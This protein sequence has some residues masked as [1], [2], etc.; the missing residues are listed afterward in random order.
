MEEVEPAGLIEREQFHLD[1][2]E[3]SKLFNLVLVA[4][5][6][7]L[8][9]ESRARGTAKL[10]ARRHI[11]SAWMKGRYAGEKNPFFGVRRCGEANPNYQNKSAK[12]PSCALGVPKSP[13]HRAK[14]SATRLER[15]C[16]KGSNHPRYK[17][18]VHRFVHVSGEVFTGSQ[19]EFTQKTCID[20]SSASAVIRGKNRSVHGWRVLGLEAVAVVDSCSMGNA[21]PS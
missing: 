10:R 20:C 2:A 19:Y 18:T 1:T 5:A 16:G 15:G 7:N 17:P 13:E 14:I 4:G 12:G 11:T 3:K 8:S 6:P 21:E 9:E